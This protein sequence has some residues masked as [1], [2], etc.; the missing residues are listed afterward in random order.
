MVKQVSLPMAVGLEQD[1][2]KV[3]SNLDH[4]VILWTKTYIL[5]GFSEKSSRV[6]YLLILPNY[7][8]TA[9]TKYCGSYNNIFFKKTYGNFN[10]KSY[11]LFITTWIHIKMF[12]FNIWVNEDTLD[13]WVIV[14]SFQHG[15]K[16][17]MCMSNVKMSCCLVLFL[18]LHLECLWNSR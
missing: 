10:D 1:I 11:W 3:P 13:I 18:F 8:S 15:Y 6:L 4:S 7:H 14:S 16:R 12:S 5:S 9:L 2:F 17:R